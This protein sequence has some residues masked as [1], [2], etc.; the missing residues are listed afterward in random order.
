MS[1]IEHIRP[2]TLYIATELM[3]KIGLRPTDTLTA[4]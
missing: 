4:Q 2:H 1:I 3:H